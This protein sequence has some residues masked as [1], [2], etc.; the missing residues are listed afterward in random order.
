MEELLSDKVMEELNRWKLPD[1]NNTV[2]DNVYFVK[3][4]RII[5]QVGKKIDDIIDRER[6]EYR[7]K[8]TAVAEHNLRLMAERDRYREALEAFTKV[9]HFH[10]PDGSTD[11]CVTCAAT[12]VLDGEG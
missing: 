8:A 1:I 3:I 2:D 12:A 5:D 6:D 11:K 7:D 10:R 4:G 9:A